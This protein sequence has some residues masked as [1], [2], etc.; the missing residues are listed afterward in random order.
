M[1]GSDLAASRVFLFYRTPDREDFATVPM[2]RNKKGVYVGTIPAE[3]TGGRSLQ[4]Y[5]EARDARGKPLMGNG[6]PASP[7]II[8]M[9]AA[10]AGQA[11]DTDENPLTQKKASTGGAAGGSAGEV[12]EKSEPEHPGKHTVWLTAAIGTGFGLATGK[13]E[14][15]RSAN[16]PD[17]GVSIAT[18]IAPAVL[19]IAPEIGFFVS[20]HLALS[21]QARL[22]VLTNAQPL[23]NAAVPA[24]GAIAGFGRLMYFFGGEHFRGYL[25]MAAGGGD[26]R[27]TVDISNAV[28]APG[29]TDTVNSGPVFFG[30]GLGFHWDFSDRVG[31]IGEL[32]SLVGLD[33]FTINVDANLGFALNL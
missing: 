4:Y 30:P 33:I 16:A 15:P 5:I 7:N 24:N 21:I 31:L 26:I 18:G 8:T 29:A 9:T 17:S 25:D 28:G 1:V 3:A 10:V 19:H 11:A 2:A 27:H 20:D 12:T 23:T 13:A 14:T 22:Q 6:S 32:Q